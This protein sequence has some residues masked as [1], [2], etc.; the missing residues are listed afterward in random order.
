MSETFRYYHPIRVRFSET[1][2]QGHV[3]FGN[4]FTYFDVAA[5]EYMR[6]IGYSYQTMGAEGVDLVYASSHCDHLGRAFF[7]ETLHVYTRIGHVG[8]T[9]LK[10]EFLVRGAGDG[11]L[12]ARG[13]IVAVMVDAEEMRP[14]RVPESFRRAIDL[15]EKGGDGS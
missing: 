8:N 9:S 7:D 4:Y 3:F 11:R 12:I 6:A 13:E 5:V 10:F 1:D 15:F 2:L 14:V